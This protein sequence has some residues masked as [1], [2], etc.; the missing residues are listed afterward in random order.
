MNLCFQISRGK[1]A[2]LY[3]IDESARGRILD[4]LDVVTCLGVLSFVPSENRAIGEMGR[5]LKPGGVLIV[6]PPNILRVNNFL[7]PYFY[8]EAGRMVQ[9]VLG[10]KLD[11]LIKSPQGRHSREGGNP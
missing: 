11:G 8:I 10:I 1:Q 2:I 9:C 3:F 4:I 5:V 7:D 6:T